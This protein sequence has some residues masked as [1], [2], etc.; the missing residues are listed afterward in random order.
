MSNEGGRWTVVRTASAVEIQIRPRRLELVIAT[1]LIW[2]F[3]LAVTAMFIFGA[4]LHTDGADSGSSRLLPILPILFV[5]LVLFT[6][7]ALSTEVIKISG[8]DFQY[9]RRIFGLGKNQTF[10]L[11]EI[12]DLRIMSAPRHSDTV[13]R[14]ITPGLFTQVGFLGF[15]YGN[16]SYRIASGISEADAKD[17]LDEVARMLPIIK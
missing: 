17:L 11:T 9:S 2:I 4:M 10:V 12:K 14:H 5:C 6:W 7:L 15:E 1:S 3:F 16:R 8:D 13:E